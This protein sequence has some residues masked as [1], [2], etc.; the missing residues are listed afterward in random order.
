MQRILCATDLSEAADVAIREA[1]AWARAEGGELVALHVIADPLAGHPLLPLLRPQPYAD[2]PALARIAA[3]TVTRRVAEVSGRPTAEFRVIVESGAPQARVP[4]VAE[5]EGADL[6]VVGH[7]GS[8][9]LKR[10]L[11]GRVAETIVRHAHCPV[12][13]ARPGP[14]GGRVLAA[15]DFSDPALPAL[16]AAAR[17]AA[18]GGTL[19]LLHSLDLPPAIPTL[20]G[21]GL[22][23]PVVVP[24]SQDDKQR[25][26]AATDEKLRTALDKLG[27]RGDTWVSEGPADAAILDA[28]DELQASL[29]VVGTVGRAG[30]RRMLLGSVAES[31]VRHAGCPVLVVRLHPAWRP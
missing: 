9:G 18:R 5:A 15:T 12:L 2:L 23:V 26:R 24:L 8:T 19:T 3:E 30:V 20:E 27:A 14:A 11:L 10:L 16:A 4:E 22:G 21:T 13:V 25:L 29:I 31:V 1:D 17:A 7:H 6:I 28:A